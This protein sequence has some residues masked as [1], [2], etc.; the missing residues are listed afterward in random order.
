MLTSTGADTVFAT[1]LIPHPSQ[2]D[3]DDSYDL[4][5]F[6]TYLI[7]HP[8]QTMEMIQY[9][10]LKFATYLIPHPSQTSRARLYNI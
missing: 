9:Q 6:A 4:Y 5:S 2:T 10:L 1:Y 3:Y 7:P 8:S